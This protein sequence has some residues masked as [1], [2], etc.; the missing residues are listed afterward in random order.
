MSAKAKRLTVAGKSYSCE[1]G[2]TVLDAL[3]RQN[4]AVPFACRQQICKS[5]IMRSLNVPPPAE[6]QKTLK[7]TLKSKN[8]FLS[9]ACIPEQDMEIAQP[10]SLTMQV[11]AQV[12]Q[13]EYLSKDIIAVLLQ[14]ETY[15]NYAAGQSI[16]L[17]NQDRVGKS[18]FITSPSS[19]KEQGLIEI[20]VPI[21]ED[22][23]FSDWIKEDLKQGDT[24]YI[25]CPMG[26]SFYIPKDLEQPLLLIGIDVGLSPLIGVMQ[27]ALENNHL[28]PVHLFH[29]VKT[30]DRFY[31]VEDLREVMGYRPSFH[32]YP[33]VE[34]MNG[35]GKGFYQGQAH[36][37]AL[38]MLPDL[39]GWRIFICGKSETLKVAQR[40]A[41]LAGATT[42]DIYAIFIS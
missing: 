12:R 27:D 21:V 25:S 11:A 22:G 8:Y 33:C 16:V 29:G 32:Y 3:L 5:C 20:H 10:E 34:E 37:V 39:T 28:A 19:Q 1:P 42:K 13:I 30:Q 17:M 18:Y 35:S 36:K 2:E 31:L 26:Q 7:D 23:Y 38:K 41:Y 15:V 24:V 4:V 40:E 6:S 14:C 9:C